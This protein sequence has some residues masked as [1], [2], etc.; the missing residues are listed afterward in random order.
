MASLRWGR[1]A[2]PP[3]YPDWELR[4]ALQALLPL[5][6]RLARTLNTRGKS[7]SFSEAEM[8]IGAGGNRNISATQEAPGASAGPGNLRG[9]GAERLHLCVPGPGR[10]A[11]ALRELLPQTPT[12]PP[13]SISRSHLCLPELVEGRLGPFK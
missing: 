8:A 9:T 10:A 4:G 11:P 5:S 2:A 13:H 1:G 3:G 7:F 6:L 12:P